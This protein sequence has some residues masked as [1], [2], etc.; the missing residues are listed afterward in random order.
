VKPLSKPFATRRW[1]AAAA[2]VILLTGLLPAAVHA[3]SR[4]TGVT[5]KQTARRANYDSR[6]SIAAAAPA[7][8]LETADRSTTPRTSAAR[9][10]R[11]SLGIQGVVDINAATG[12]PRQVARI[13][14]FL[15]GPSRQSPQTVVLGYLEA[16]RDV[17]GLDDAALSNLVFRQDYQDIAGTHHLSLVQ[18]VGD[19]PVFDNGI[20]AHVAKDGRLI[21]VDGAPLASLPA[22]AGAAKITAASARTAVVDDV[23]GKPVTVTGTADNAV[24]TTTFDDGGNATLVYFQ[25]SSG[26]R[27]AWQTLDMADGY[28]HVVDAATGSVLFRQSIVESD[29]DADSASTWADYPGAPVGG[30]PRTVG[31]SKWLPPNA[32]QLSGNIAHVYSD[33]NDDNVANPAEEVAPAAGHGFDFPFQDFTTTV[34]AP[35]ST[36]LKCSWDPGT[37]NSWQANRSQNAAQMYYFLGTWHD[38]LESKPI[39]FTRAAG[40]F[41]AVDGDAVQGQSDDGADTANGLPDT[42]H[43][44]NANMSTPPD[45]TP[46]VMQMYLWSPPQFVAGNSGDDSD[47]VF[48]E[49]THGLSNRLVVDANGVSA[50]NSAQSDAMGEA[51]SDWYAEDYLVDQ[52]LERDTSTIGDVRVGRYVAAGDTTRSQP[53]DCPVGTTAEICAGTAAA[54]S[55][56]YTYGDYGKID[57]GNAHADGEIWAETLWDLRAAIGSGTAE[58]LIT[59]AMELS[60]TNPSF[61]DERNAILQADVVVD[62]GKL[63]QKIWTVFAKRGMGFFAAAVDGDDPGP[64]EDF[65]TPPSSNTARGTLTGT[66]TDQDSGAAAAGV[67][68]SFGGHASGFGGDYSATTGANG[69]YTIAGIVPGT[70]VKVLS[71]GGGFDRT[72]QTVTIRPTTQTV[73]WRARRDW[74]ASSGGAGVVSFTGHDYGQ[75]GCGPGSLIDQSAGAGWASDV[76]DGGQQ[77]VLK[78]PVAV[79]VS[80]LVINPAATCGDDPTAGVGTYR[81]ETSPD[82][83][84]WAQAAAGSFPN[85]TATATEVP[86]TDGPVGFQFVRFTEL[87]SQAQDAGLCTGTSPAANGCAFLDSTELAVYGSDAG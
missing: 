4:P 19:V 71:S 30:K 37:P 49:Y 84:T 33:V 55:G 34:G 56:G 76:A 3:A 42:L 18:T 87:T 23:A 48:H 41:E 15:T 32:P 46:P 67:T 13:N 36:Q 57:A 85:G 79:N 35:C 83:T 10:L 27:L 75:F 44:N 74:A 65:S 8:P 20:R 43:R 64:V 70:Y 63:Q 82:G 51:W 12:T 47:V 60:P 22:S 62:G 28:I 14:G 80:Q 39:G 61:L 26:P 40:N 54:G 81:V 9:A 86:V 16:H 17:F 68:V 7:R 58:S 45:G 5:A 73:D 25:T 21:A 52:G 31:L 50:L 2:G 72:V 38:H 59:R 78:L 69:K 1:G 53:L 77:I 24:R 11:D 6:R 29:T 66:V